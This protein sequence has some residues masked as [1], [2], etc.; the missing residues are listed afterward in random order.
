M[1]HSPNAFTLI[2]LLIVVA[3]IGILAAIAIPNFLEAQVRAKV[4]RSYADFHTLSLAM[5]MYNT[6]TDSFPPDY[7][8]DEMS[9]WRFLTTPLAYTTKVPFDPFN[10]AYDPVR[11]SKENAYVYFA[12]NHDWPAGTA[13][14][15]DT[16]GYLIFGIGPNSRW[17]FWDFPDYSI[18]L[19]GEGPVAIRDMLYDPTNGTTSYGEL[20][21]TRRGIYNV[22]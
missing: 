9:S 2:E 16:A 3:I 4:S 7:G 12:Y 14:Y 13:K 6:D 19:V 21:A 22:E 15:I 20:V 17:D 1:K 10:S 8:P 11:Q 5:E 18:V